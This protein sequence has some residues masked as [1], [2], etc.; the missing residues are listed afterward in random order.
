M[1]PWGGSDELWD[2]LDPMLPQ[3]LG[4]GF[5]FG[6]TSSNSSAASPSTANSAH[7]VGRC[8]GKEAEEFDDE[9][10]RPTGGL[11]AGGRR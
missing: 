10:H 1:S 5:G 11:R 7:C 9:P 2:R 8:K 3:D 6:M 4:F